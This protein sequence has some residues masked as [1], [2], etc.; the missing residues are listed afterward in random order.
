MLRRALIISILD[1]F[2]TITSKILSVKHSIKS[3][4]ASCN[5]PSFYKSGVESYIVAEI[6]F[7]FSLVK[8]VQS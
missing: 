6:H 8:L 4:I 7:K 5:S 1:F 2:V 3:L